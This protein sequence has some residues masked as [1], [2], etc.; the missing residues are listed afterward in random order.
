MKDFAEILRQKYSPNYNVK[1][2]ELSFC[3][4]KT[5]SFF[6]SRV[7]LIMPL[8]NKNY[9]I[10]ND[11]SIRILGIEY[12]PLEET[13]IEMANGMIEAGYIPNKLGE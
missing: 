6:D 4:M 9:N 10:I 1:S 13:V 11:R 8:W 5:V 7:K 3:T 12:I 2:K